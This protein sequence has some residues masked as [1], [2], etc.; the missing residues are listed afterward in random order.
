MRGNASFAITRPQSGEGPVVFASPHSGRIYPQ[1]FLSACRAALMDLRRIEDAYL[2]EVISQAPAQGCVTIAGLIGRAVI[3]LNRS[4]D[5]IDPDMFV[6]P[7]PEWKGSRSLRVEAGL[8]CFPKTAHRSEPIYRRKLRRIEAEE[9]L[10]HIYRPYHAALEALLTA[11]EARHGFCILVDC[12][13]MP[14]P[15]QQTGPDADI[16]IGDR[17]GSSCRPDLSDA[18]EAFFTDAG[19]K[20]TRNQPYAGGFATLRHGRPAAGRE[21]I[22]I[23][24]ARRL[25][26]SEVAA[27]P[28]KGIV[29]LQEVMARLASRLNAFASDC[30][31]PPAGA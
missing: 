30:R 3:D 6:D 29:H 24:I 8:G 19:Y 28:H 7:A 26:L 21:A 15:L 22:Q 11:A 27:E 5:D 2:D 16:I 9:R 4:T 31:P 17:F 14:S 25:Y 18:V 13:S 10:E 20:T 1:D 23:E 12:H